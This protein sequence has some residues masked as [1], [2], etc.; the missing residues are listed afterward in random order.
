MEHRNETAANCSLML[1]DNSGVVTFEWND[2]GKTLVTALNW[3]WQF[4]D[5]SKMPVAVEFGAV[6]L[7]NH[8]GSA[9]I[10]AVGHG[11]SVTFAT[12]QAVDDLLRLAD[13]IAIRTK[14]DEMSIKLRPDKV[15][16]LLSRLRDCRDVIRR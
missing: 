1:Y 11:N 12:D 4:P 6:W 7:T 13:H 2:R 3:S 16:V 9:V 5:N 8:D 14:Y 15:A 10:T